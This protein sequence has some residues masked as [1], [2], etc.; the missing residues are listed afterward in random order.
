MHS[1]LSLRAF[2]ALIDSLSSTILKR[3]NQRSD[4]IYRRQLFRLLLHIWTEGG[5]DR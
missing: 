3:L 5:V 4:S 1:A 2:L